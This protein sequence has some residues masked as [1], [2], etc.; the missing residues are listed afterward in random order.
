M[1]K[2]IPNTILKPFWLEKTLETIILFS[3]LI[4]VKY[5]LNHY[6]FEQAILWSDILFTIIICIPYLIASLTSKTIIH[7]ETKTIKNIYYGKITNYHLDD[8]LSMTIYP[9]NKFVGNIKLHLK[10][11]KDKGISISD[12]SSF[13]DEIKNLSNEIIIEYK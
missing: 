10:N 5:L 3:L 2:Y 6:G 8:I 13:T 12:I 9:N 4:I 7:K 1:K 11:G